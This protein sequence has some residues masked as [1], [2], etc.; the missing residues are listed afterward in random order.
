[1]VTERSDKVAALA[2]ALEGYWRGMIGLNSDTTY[3]ELEGLDIDMMAAVYAVRSLGT[4]LDTFDGQTL[5]VQAA[6]DA[7]RRDAD[8]LIMLTNVDSSEQD[9]I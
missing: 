7:G 5:T 4:F 6:Y 1:M 8:T 3:G 2:D 9:R